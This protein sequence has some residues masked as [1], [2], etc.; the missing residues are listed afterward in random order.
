MKKT[1]L[2]EAALLLKRVLAALLTSAGNSTTLAGADL[3]KKVGALSATAEAAIQTGQLG[4]PLLGCFDAAFTAGATLNTIFQVRTLILAA[5]PVG[6]AGITVQ[7]ACLR[8]ALVEESKIL[9]V[10]PLV[11]RQDVDSYLARMNAAFD[12]AETFAADA[13][14]TI[15]YRALVALHAVVSQ[16]LATR[17]RALPRIVPYSYPVRFPALTLANR[18][19]ADASRAGELIAENKIVHPLFMPRD[20]VALSG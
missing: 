19:Y 10:T 1:A 15:V 2:A 18:L 5:K 16:D 20:G 3:F 7:Q 8:M 11:S 6:A 12:P 14:D 17:G 4:A 13:R 9:A